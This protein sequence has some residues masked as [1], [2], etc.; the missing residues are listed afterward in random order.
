MVDFSLDIVA[1]GLHV[2]TCS[3]S[4]RRRSS[5]SDWRISA[6]GEP[7]QEFLLGLTVCA[8]AGDVE[9]V[10]D[11]VSEMRIHYGSGYRVYFAATGRKVRLL[12]CGGDKST[13]QADIRR[14]LDIA[15]E[16]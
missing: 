14:A 6:I 15:S 2:V 13:Q 3:R 4:N 5:G 1:G 16:L 11:G 12:L 9:P 7:L 10:G 8:W